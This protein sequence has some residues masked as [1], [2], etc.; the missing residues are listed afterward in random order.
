MYLKVGYINLKSVKL[1]RLF[2]DNSIVSLCRCGNRIEIN[3]C[4]KH[5]AVVMVGV[6]S[7]YLGSARCAEKLYRIV[8]AKK[9]DELVDY[10][11]ISFFLILNSLVAEI[12]LF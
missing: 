7:A 4:G 12:N 5:L 6:I 11:R 10:S 8:I 2:N 3:A 9:L 1:E